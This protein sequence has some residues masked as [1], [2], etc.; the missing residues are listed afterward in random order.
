MV[1]QRCGRIRLSSY[2]PGRTL[3]LR[4]GSATV[5]GFRRVGTIRIG[6]LYRSLDDRGVEVLRVEP[7]LKYGNSFL[8]AAVEV[9]YRRTYQ[10]LYMP[11]I[12]IFRYDGSETYTLPVSASRESDWSHRWLGPRIFWRLKEDLIDPRQSPPPWATSFRKDC[13]C[14]ISK[15]KDK[16]RDVYQ[17]AELAGEKV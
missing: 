11:V 1:G 5:A 9:C 8:Q 6:R 16:E 7:A 14:K 17:Y 15:D 10:T 12:Y 3:R 4:M 13:E 2:F